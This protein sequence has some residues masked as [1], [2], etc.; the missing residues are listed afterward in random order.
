MKNLKIHEVS[1]YGEWKNYDTSES[2]RGTDISR[3]KYEFNFV[4]SLK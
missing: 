2:N 3:E 1:N 4:L